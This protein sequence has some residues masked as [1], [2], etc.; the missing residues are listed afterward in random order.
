VYKDLEPG[1]DSM[2]GDWSGRV[3]AHAAIADAVERHR[4]H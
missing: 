2:L 1:K 4:R 3:E